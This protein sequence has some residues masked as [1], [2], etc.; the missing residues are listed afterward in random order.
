MSVVG[1]VVWFLAL[2]AFSALEG[3]QSGRV[4]ERE[5]VRVDTLHVWHCDT[6]REVHNDTVYSIVQKVVHDSIVSQVIIKE[7]MNEDG[8]VIHSEK[9]TNNEV[10]HNAESDYQL[11]QHKVDSILKAKVDSI[12]HSTYNEKS[13]LVEK[14]TPWYEKAWRWIVDKFAWIGLAVIL[15]LGAKFLCPLIWKK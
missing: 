1:V 13:V 4:L 7:V 3:C 9:E 11:I 5:V 6:L 8:E 10:W 2:L 14:E 15:L 12:T